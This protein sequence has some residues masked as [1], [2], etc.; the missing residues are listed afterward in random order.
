MISSNQIIP[1]VAGGVNADSC[2]SH[3]KYKQDA[4]VKVIP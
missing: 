3:Y 4:A 2:I 1:P